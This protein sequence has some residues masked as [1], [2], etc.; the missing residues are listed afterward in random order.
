MATNKNWRN[1]PLSIDQW[2]ENC[3]KSEHVRQEDVVEFYEDTKRGVVYCDIQDTMVS[4]GCYFIKGDDV[5]KGWN[6]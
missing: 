1:E 6:H 4:I 2:K 3:K 5:G